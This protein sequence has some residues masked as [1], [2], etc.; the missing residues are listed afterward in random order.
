MTNSLSTYLNDELKKRGWSQRELARRAE[1]SPTSISEVLSGRR[2]PG[3]RFCQAVAQAL[4]VPPERILQAAGIL[5][6][7]PDTA[8]FSELT[9]IAKRLSEP[10]QK[11][12]VEYAQFLMQTERN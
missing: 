5:D 12:L 10:N 4:Q 8:L 11:K 2:G 1:L 7:P 3:R 9:N 6:A